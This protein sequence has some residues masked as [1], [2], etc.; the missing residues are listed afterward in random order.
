MLTIELLHEL[1]TVC[2]ACS[3]TSLQTHVWPKHVLGF[4]HAADMLKACITGANDTSTAPTARQITGASVSE[5]WPHRVLPLF[6]HNDLMCR[7]CRVASRLGLVFARGWL[8][9]CFQGR[10]CAIVACIA[11]TAWCGGGVLQGRGVAFARGCNLAGTPAGS[12]PVQGCGSCHASSCDSHNK[13]S[14]GRHRQVHGNQQRLPPNA[15][16]VHAVSH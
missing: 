13:H 3:G 11:A 7:L 1:H 8:A 16:R 12:V 10:L 4:P 6:V 15:Q 14:P 2:P 9:D 5:Q